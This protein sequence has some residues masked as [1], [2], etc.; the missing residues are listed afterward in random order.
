M[1]ALAILQ[2]NFTK[3]VELSI[4]DFEGPV[5]YFTAVIKF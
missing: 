5:E 2:T 4:V 1:L 3:A